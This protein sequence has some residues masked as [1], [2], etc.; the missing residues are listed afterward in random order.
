[1]RHRILRRT[2]TSPV[3]TLRILAAVASLTATTGCGSSGTD[4]GTSPGPTTSI[5]TAAGNSQN[6]TVGKPV[7]TAPAVIVTS[8]STPKAGVPVTFAVASGG[9]SITGATA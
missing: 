9:G 4:S 2:A 1:M 7:A 3:A 5:A 8:N 6:A